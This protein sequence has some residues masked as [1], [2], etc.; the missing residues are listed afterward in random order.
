MNLIYWVVQ[1]KPLI[2]LIIAI[3]GFVGN[4]VLYLHLTRGKCNR[5]DFTYFWRLWR[6]GE[7]DGRIVM[8]SSFLALFL[9]IILIFSMVTIK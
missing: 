9:G 5:D 2:I 3:C 7:R 6:S 1:H 4:Y 8:Y